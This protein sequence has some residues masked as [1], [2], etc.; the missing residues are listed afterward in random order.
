MS[1]IRTVIKKISADPI[2]PGWILMILSCRDGNGPSDFL[3]SGNLL[4]DH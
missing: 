3:P 2:C 4:P 1:K